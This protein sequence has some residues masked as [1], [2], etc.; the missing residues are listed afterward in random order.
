MKYLIN[1][2]LFTRLLFWLCYCYR[3]KPFGKTLVYYSKY[4][5]ADILIPYKIHKKDLPRLLLKILTNLKIL[6]VLGDIL[7]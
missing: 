1:S 4:F 5:V 7:L 6:Q 3:E 2:V